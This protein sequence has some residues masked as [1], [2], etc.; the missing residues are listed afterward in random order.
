M[1]SSLHAYDFEK[2]G[3]Y[4]N[5]KGEEAVVTHSDV[6]VI[7]LDN[8]EEYTQPFKII[9]PESVKYNKKNYPVTKIEAKAF[10]SSVKKL[11]SIKIPES[12][13]SIGTAAF[14]RC[15]DLS[16]VNIPESITIIE[17]EVFSGCE[18]LKTI[19]IPKGVNTIGNEAFCGCVAL[20][21]I[22]CYALEPPMVETDSFK[23]VKASD[24]TL[25]VP[26]DAVENYKKHTIWGQFNIYA[27][28]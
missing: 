17:S 12:V 6:L 16:F 24:V 9:I 23:D 8:I 28:K 13:V 22:Y 7:S 1:Y 20:K 10:A 19:N 5:I 21:K 2:K 26:A 14:R 15:K 27:G 3:V 25:Y 4:Y 11:V 18:H